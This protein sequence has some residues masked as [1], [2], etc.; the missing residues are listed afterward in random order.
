[1]NF[2]REDIRTELEA[3]L[4]GIQGVKN[5][6]SYRLTPID[7]H[8]TPAINI[9]PMSDESD[10]SSMRQAFRRI[11]TYRVEALLCR[12]KDDDDFPA[13]C[14]RLYEN[15][16]RAILKFKPCKIKCPKVI[17]GRKTWAVDT[18]GQVP[19]CVI[20]FTVQVEFE[21]VSDD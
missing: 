7:P 12:L 13:T 8:D 9:L 18:D 15:T 17:I 4:T 2:E 1:M 5:V 20:K 10:E 11:E 3:H 19:M 21:Q 6:F 16:R 14:D